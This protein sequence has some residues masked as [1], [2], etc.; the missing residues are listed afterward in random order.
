MSDFQFNQ[1]QNCLLNSKYVSK[2]QDYAD[3]NDKWVIN[4][5]FDKNDNGIFN[6][7]FDHSLLKIDPNINTNTANFTSIIKNDDPIFKDHLSNNLSLDE[8]SPAIESGNFQITSNNS[9]F[10]DINGENR[11]DP[12]D[13]GAY[14]YID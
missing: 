7:H 13:L 8:N 3:K 11:N 5:N 1:T 14:Q 6:Y 2:S 12:P 4:R 9:L 10:T